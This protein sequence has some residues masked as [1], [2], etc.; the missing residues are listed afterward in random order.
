MI[1]ELL[2]FQLSQDVSAVIIYKAVPEYKI[3]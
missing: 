3:K 1:K 2:P